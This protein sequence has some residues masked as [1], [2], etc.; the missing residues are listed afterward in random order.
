[1]NAILDFPRFLSWGAAVWGILGLFWVVLPWLFVFGV[2][3]R[4]VLRGGGILSGGWGLSWGVL[5]TRGFVRGIVRRGFSA[6]FCLGVFVRGALPG[7]FSP[8]GFV[9]WCFIQECGV[10][11]AQIYSMILTEVV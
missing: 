11:G 10:H 6:G 5:S 2:F 3:C 8:G 1:M 9:R 7:V 4:A